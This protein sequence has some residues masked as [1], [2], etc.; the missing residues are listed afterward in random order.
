MGF[1]TSCDAS[2]S[3]VDVETKHTSLFAARDILKMFLPETHGQIID[4]V[5]VQ[6]Y[7]LHY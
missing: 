7:V 2:V 3:H 5:L 6:A 1:V 4:A